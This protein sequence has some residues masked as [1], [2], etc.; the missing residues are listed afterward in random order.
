[1]GKLKKET[2]FV[3]AAQIVRVKSRRTGQDGN[4]TEKKIWVENLRLMDVCNTKLTAFRL[5]KNS[6]PK[7]PE[8]LAKGDTLA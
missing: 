5:A 2:G 1:M 3:D 8:K 4:N 6:L 7:R